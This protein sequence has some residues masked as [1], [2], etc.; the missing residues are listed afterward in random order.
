VS[1]VSDELQRNE[2]GGSYVPS[3]AHQK[4]YGRRKA[5]K[6]QGMQIVAHPTVR[7]FIEREL[8]KQQSPAAIAGRLA[9]GIDN[10]PYVS[11]NSIYRY[12][13]SVH[14]RQLEHEL[15]LL[16]QKRKNGRK[17]SPNVEALAHRTFIDERPT[18]I[19]NRERIGDLEADFIVSGKSGSGALLT[20]VDRRVRYGFIRKILPVSITNVEQAFLDIRSNFPE[21]SSVTLDNDILF[22]FH[23]RLEQLLGVPIY[24]THPYA[25][26]QKG[27]IE[28][29][30]GQVRKYVRKGT[31]VSQ[32]NEA[33]L[34]FVA[35]RL[36]NR[37][38]SVLGYQT[39]QESLRAVRLEG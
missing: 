14:G 33:Y 5:A 18:V 6:Y 10:L 2:I 35:K 38:M 31:D 30:N 9:T 13:A 11:K 4:A 23:E 16:K 21:L 22:R 39:P 28:N 17:R 7:V 24:F 1:T 12:I 19:T 26:W 32:Y 34:E 27:S 20:A 3:K 25:S 36:N 37:F 15:K 29:F 8:L